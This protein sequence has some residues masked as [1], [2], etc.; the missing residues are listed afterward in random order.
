MYLYCLFRLV[1]IDNLTR[2][3]MEFN[4]WTLHLFSTGGFENSV[5]FLIG[6]FPCFN[7]LYPSI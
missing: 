7:C 1:Q 6:L 3:S 4:V 5:D 2:Q